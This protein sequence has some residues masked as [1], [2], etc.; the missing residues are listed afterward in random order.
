MR[1][2][3]RASS[4]TGGGWGRHSVD[5]DFVRLGFGATGAS[6]RHG[7]DIPC[8]EVTGP[9]SG[10][11]GSQSYLGFEAEHRIDV[12]DSCVRA[13]RGGFRPNLWATQCHRQLQTQWHS[14][15]GGLRITGM[16]LVLRSWFSPRSARQLSEYGRWQPQHHWDSQEPNP[17]LRDSLVVTR[18]CPS[19]CCFRGSARV[20]QRSCTEGYWQLDA[21]NQTCVR[22]VAS[23]KLGPVRT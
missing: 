20:S 19:L 15:S 11:A 18:L 12:T 9:H 13:A 10:P 2:G 4:P 21:S 5:V 7:A 1:A 6:L 22:H 8:P 16:L 14:H 17:S 23:T 3:K